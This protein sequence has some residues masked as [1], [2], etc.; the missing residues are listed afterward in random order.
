MV[1]EGALRCDAEYIV[2]RNT[3]DFRNSKV[4]AISPADFLERYKKKDRSINR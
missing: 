2:T 1:Y 3:D 4:P